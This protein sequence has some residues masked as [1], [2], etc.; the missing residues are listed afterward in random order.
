MNSRSETDPALRALH[1]LCPECGA[2]ITVAAAAEAAPIDALTLGIAM[3]MV[4]E[5]DAR[6][7]VLNRGRKVD[8]IIA[9]YAALR[10]P[11]TETAGEAG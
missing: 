1:T 7:G 8:R 2:A 6:L 10:S 4:D 9:R 5:E 11:D 3:D